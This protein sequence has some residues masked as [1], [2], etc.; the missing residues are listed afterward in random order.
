MY[1]IRV[2]RLWDIN[3]MGDAQ[4]SADRLEILVGIFQQLG[5]TGQQERT[6]PLKDSRSAL[7]VHGVNGVST[8][9]A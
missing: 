2:D 3:W 7:G 1:I 4:H 8:G 6:G 9:D 5:L